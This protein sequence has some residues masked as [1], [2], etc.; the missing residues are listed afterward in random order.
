M[1][2]DTLGLHRGTPVKK[3]RLVTWIRYGVMKSRQK[4][5][6]TAETL[7]NKVTLSREN[8]SIL[9]SSKFKDVLSDI[10]KIN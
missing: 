3:N 8:M 5:L 10:V 4:N 7:S 6:N 9:K 2:C 1:A